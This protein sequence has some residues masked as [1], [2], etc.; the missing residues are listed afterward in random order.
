MLG[1][2]R[3]LDEIRRKAQKMMRSHERVLGV[4]SLLSLI[5]DLGNIAH[6]WSTD[7]YLSLFSRPCR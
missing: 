3:Q 1:K 2:E 4:D 7:I 6:L 5:Q